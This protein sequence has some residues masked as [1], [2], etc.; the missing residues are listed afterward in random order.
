MWEAVFCSASKDPWHANWWH[1]IL[2]IR[3]P[4][5]SQHPVSQG[6]QPDPPMSQQLLSRH[7][8]HCVWGNSQDGTGWFFLSWLVRDSSFTSHLQITMGCCSPQERKCMW[9]TLHNGTRVTAFSSNLGLQSSV[10]SAPGGVSNTNK[11]STKTSC[12]RIAALRRYCR[13]ISAP[14]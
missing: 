12:W 1:C 7:T 14:D 3:G 13:Q 11:F 4:C 2:I 9:E 6:R 5:W 8:S 10:S